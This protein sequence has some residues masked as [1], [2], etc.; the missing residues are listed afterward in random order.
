MSR[1]DD[2]TPINVLYYLYH[3]KHYKLIGINLSR[4]ANLSIP[5]QINFV[6]IFLA[7]K[8]QKTKI[9]SKLFFRFINLT[10]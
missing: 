2:D 5:Q 7:K 8:K 9:N 1:N 3:Q 10:E 6:I 4:Q